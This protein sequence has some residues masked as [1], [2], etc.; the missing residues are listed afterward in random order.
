MATNKRRVAIVGTGHRGTSTWGREVFDTCDDHVALVGLADLND[1]RLAV[2]AG[3][4]GGE[5]VRSTDLDAMLG[6]PRPVMRM[7][8]DGLRDEWRDIDGYAEFVGLDAAR[9]SAV[10]SNLRFEQP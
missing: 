6:S 9:R 1:A 4:V 2:A 7:T 3:K 8:I 10:R 5:P